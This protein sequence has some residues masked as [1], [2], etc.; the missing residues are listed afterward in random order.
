MGYAEKRGKKGRREVK[1]ILVNFCKLL[2]IKGNIFQ[3]VTDGSRNA[4]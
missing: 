2:G 1:N 4:R 3:R